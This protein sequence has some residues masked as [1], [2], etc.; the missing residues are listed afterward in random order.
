MKKIVWI[1]PVLALLLA[2]CSGNTYSKE[3]KEEKNVINDYLKRENIQVVDT[4]PNIQGSWPEKLY[5]QVSGR[6]NLYYHLVK[7]GDTTRKAIVINEKVIIRYR[8]YT[9]TEDKDIVQSTWTTLDAPHPIE[10]KY[11]VDYTQACTAWHIAVGLMQYPDSECKIICPS[12]LG[13]EADGSAVVPYGY[14]I[15]IQINR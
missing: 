15:K 8:K 1:L 10:F 13:F 6:D 3:L 2:S 14:D 12:K 11:L 7:T 4:L 5:Y 9:L